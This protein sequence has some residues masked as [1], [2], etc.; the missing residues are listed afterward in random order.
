[1]TYHLLHESA[2]PADKVRTVNGDAD[3][4]PWI[5]TG[6]AADA[7]RPSL[8]GNGLSSDLAATTLN[9]RDGS[10]WVG[11]STADSIAIDGHTTV[12]NSKNG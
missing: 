5:G 4:K 8:K 10:P 3:G 2:G 7:Q 1:M 11:T 6:K 9:G 12:Y